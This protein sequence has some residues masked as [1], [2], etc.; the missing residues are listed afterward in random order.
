MFLG[1]VRKQLEH[2]LFPILIAITL[3]LTI[4]C[5][6]TAKDHFEAETQRNF[7]WSVVSRTNTVYLL[8]SLHILKREV[9]PLSKEI[10]SAYVHSKTVVFE[11]DLQGMQNPTV[12]AKMIA[13]GL[14][15]EGQ[16]LKQNVSPETYGILK[17]KAIMHGLTMAQ[18]DRL[19]PWLCALTLATM[20]LQRL[21]FDPNYGIDRYFFNKATIDG[22]EIRFLETIEYQLHLLA[23]MGKRQQESLLRQTL[24]ELEVMESKAS[25]VVNA[26]KKGD[27][28]WLQSIVRISFKAYPEIYDRLFTQRNKQWIA[29]IEKLLKRHEKALVIVGAGHLVG[30]ESIV[31]LLGRRGYQVTQR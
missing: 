21:G 1:Y 27:V 25:D 13:L 17:K 7:L 4:T 19:K 28:D 29:Q 23:K 24:E 10:E 9:L 16:T 31:K 12:Q 8:G 26:W 14:Y 5:I 11:T 15:P 30:R 18:L 2:Q 22:K 20:E 3:L 6:A